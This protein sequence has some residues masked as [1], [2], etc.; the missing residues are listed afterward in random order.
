MSARV[1]VPLQIAGTS[2]PWGQTVHALQGQTMGTTWSARV[3]A[4]AEL[5]LA[6]IEAAI[7]RMLAEVIAQMSPWEPDSDLSRFNRAPAGSRHVLPAGFATVMDAALQVAAAS[8]GAFDPT[9]GELVRRWGFGPPGPAQAARCDWRALQWDGRAL[10]Q[11]GMARLDLSAIAKGY[12]VDRLSQL[13]LECG[14]PHHLAEIGGELRGAG[15]KPEGQPWWVDLEPPAADCG[16]APLRMAL[17]GLSIAT[18]GDYRRCYIDAQGQRRSHTIDP[19]S[20]EPIAHGLAAV[21]VVHESAMWA[22]GWSTALMVMGAE[23]GLRFA[24]E[25]GLAALFTQRRADGF[26]ELFTPAMKAMLT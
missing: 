8:D 26:E 1:L 17:H 7:K 10:T 4:P 11:S 18:S 19:R 23:A 21:S 20:G 15:F 9:S 25:R 22:D 13:L 16:L 3:V 24:T 14:L 6:P 2:P 5:R 12:A